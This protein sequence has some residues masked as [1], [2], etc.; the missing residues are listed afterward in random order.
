MSSF[1][2]AETL[3]LAMLTLHL[4]TQRSRARR[5]WQSSSPQGSAQ[6]AV[7]DTFKQLR[8]LHCSSEEQGS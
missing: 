2:K 1:I 7:G 5:M 6:S 3:K 4:R 8:S